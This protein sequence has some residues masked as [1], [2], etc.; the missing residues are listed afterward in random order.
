MAA[1]RDSL[2]ARRDIRLGEHIWRVVSLEAAEAAGAGPLSRLPR[3]LK[4][5]AENVLRHEDGL[6]IGAPQLAALKG[7]GDPAAV[8]QEVPYHPTR[9]VMNDSGGLPAM[10]DLAALRD[11]VVRAGGD[12]RRINPRVPAD[13]VVDHSIMVDHA[14]S[15]DAAARNLDLEYERNA[16]RYRF[17]RWCQGAFDNFRVVPPGNGILHQVN[18]ESF[19]RCVWTETRGNQ[20]WAFP[21]TLLGTDSHTPMINA[22]GVFGWGVG[23][24]EAAAAILGQPIGIVL[25]RVV[26]CR[27]TGALPR[28]VTATDAVLMVTQKL[29]AVGVVASY[30]EFFGPGLAALNVFDRATLANMAPEYGATMGFFPVDAQTISFL[31]MTGR[32]GDHA[33]LVESYCRMQ[34]LWH[35]AA[36][37]QP[38]YAEVVEI[39]LSEAEPSAAGPRRPQDRVALPRIRDSFE[40][41]FPPAPEAEGRLSDGAVVIAAITSCTNTSNAQ[42]M[43]AA[44]LLARKAVARGLRAKPWVKTSLAPGSRVVADYLEATGL[45]APLDALGFHLIGFGCTT[46]M[47]NSGPLPPETE[48]AI[49]AG[50]TTAVAVLSGNRNF[51]G[52]IHTQAK[53][54]YIMSPPLVVAHAL[55]G[56]VRIDMTRE[57][58][59]TG[60]DGQPVFLAD[61]WPSPEEIAQAASVALNAPRFTN[62][63]ATVFQGDARWEALP[64]PKGDTFPWEGESLYLNEPPFLREVPREAAAIPDITGARA[65][66]LLGDSITTDHISPVGI[67]TPGSAAGQYL[68]SLG[69]PPAEF[70]SFAARR[71]KHEV[72]IRG[73]FANIRIQNRLAAGRTG[74]WTRH[75]PSGEILPVHEAAERYAAEGVPLV[76]VAGQDYGAGSSR[77]W[78][79]KGTLLLGVRAVIA[80]GFERIHRANL[81]YMGVLPLELPAGV[82]VETLGLDGTERWDIAGIHPAPEPGAGLPARLHRADGRV[83][84][85]TLRCRLDTPFEAECF[86]AGGILPRVLRASLVAE[87]A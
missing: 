26:G 42:N 67:I 49:E 7:W 24:I 5:L 12:P 36:G 83:E 59:G 66:A 68:I 8:G 13:M 50:Q 11:A 33:R 1:E 34:G 53:A 37:V 86:R 77:D 61:I 31:E 46:C 51:E 17:L 56:T 43:L 74:G 48:A 78:A 60:H 45:Q 39:N 65:L 41:A 79:A 22:I 27:L 75:E 84:E 18:L 72:M 54:N 55:A 71:V 63:Y 57:P 20:R 87:A 85:L 6:V 73:T 16:E 19:A 23:G 10:A 82:T 64:A 47:G 80:N 44:G 40:A 52:R 69:V 58:L 30:V 9:V 35:D 81:V 29:R 2:G 32:G 14:G 70:N 21:E 28:G 76:V 15:P 3:S 62:R 38:D 4:V 25:P